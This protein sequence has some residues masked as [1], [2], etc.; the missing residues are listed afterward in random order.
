MTF[1]ADIIALNTIQAGESVG[2]GSTFVAQTNH[3]AVSYCY[4]LL[5]MVMVIHAPSQNKTT[6]MLMVKQAV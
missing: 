3:H 2:Y 6:S 5:V 4:S 1:T